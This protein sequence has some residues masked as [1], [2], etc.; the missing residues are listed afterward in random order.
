MKILYLI[1]A[2]AGSKS[3][4]NK[5]ITKLGGKEL[6]VYRI[7]AAKH[8]ADTNDIW[9]ST[10]S[11]EYAQ[12]GEKAG[13]VVP[14]IRPSN[15]AEDETPSVDV[16][17]HA[18]NYAE[19]IGKK[20]DA[21]CLLEPTVPFVPYKFLRDAEKLL[22]DKRIEN[23]VSIRKVTPSS[24][25]VQKQETYLTEIAKNVKNNNGVKRRQEEDEEITPSGGFYF[26]KWESFKRNKSFYTSKTLAYKI[27]EIYSHEIDE[28]IDLMWAEFLLEKGL[29][30][31]NE[32]I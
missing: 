28:P 15:L 31:L 14:F 19:K 12:I 22:Y 27:D 5:N 3:I 24:F 18:M 8:V 20:Y 2:R 30:K 23:I 17:L 29:I 26:A 21:I 6:L 1:T 25:F 13:A 9:L 10:D 11:E 32:I 16:V 4:P 7:E